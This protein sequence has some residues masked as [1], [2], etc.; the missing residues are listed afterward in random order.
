MS[1]KN[2]NQIATQVET[3]QAVMNDSMKAMLAQ[4]GQLGFEGADLES[5]A[6]PFLRVIQK[7]SP[8]V[9]EMDPAFKEDAKP[10]MLF[11]SVTETLYPKTGVLFL[12]CAYTRQFLLWGPRSGSGSGF[13]GVMPPNLY[14]EAKAAR[15]IQSYEGREY[16]LTKANEDFSPET[17]VRVTDTRSHFGLILDENGP[18]K[19]VLAL[20][21]TQIKKSKQLLTML[22]SSRLKVDG[23]L[24]TV[25]TWFN[26]VLIETV[27]ESNDKGSWHGVK[28]SIK[29]NL[30]D[31]DWKNKDYSNTDLYAMGKA[32]H[33]DVV[34]GQAE[35]NYEKAFEEDADSDK[36]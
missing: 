13:Q 10:G 19:A 24:I 23:A 29:T 16:L 4:D 6:I 11:N 33:D 5:Y 8:Q 20:S 28:F 34:A 17:S 9:D 30:Y 26:V 2:A 35:V 32:F 7:M 31:L 22:S 18:Q 25:P 15:K 27:G 1:R 3:L 21:S 36:F 12:P 14:H